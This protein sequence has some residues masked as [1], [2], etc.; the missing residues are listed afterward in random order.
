MSEMWDDIATFH[1]KFSIP[2]QEL[3]S[4]PSK[5]MMEFRIKF[6]QEELDEFVVAYGNENLVKGFDA[7]IDLVY[8]AMGTAYIMNVPWDKGWYRVQA[9]NLAKV[10]AKKASHS[11]RGSTFDVVKPTGWVPPD[12]LLLA[13]VLLHEHA[14][15]MRRHKDPLGPYKTEDDNE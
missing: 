4:Y 6:L 14:M 9:A 12:Q 7:L 3:P 13:E 15:L 5:E 11:T 2:Q 10:R 8:V 1:K